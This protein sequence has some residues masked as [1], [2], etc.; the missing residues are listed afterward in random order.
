ML[1]TGAPPESKKLF[2]D[3]ELEHY[4]HSFIAS[5]DRVRYLLLISLVAS[6]LAFMA[7]W[8]SLPISWLDTRTE[9]ARIAYRNKL[10]EDPEKRLEI[11]H[12]KGRAAAGFLDSC[13]T[14][15]ENLQWVSSRKHGEIS[16]KAHLEKLEQLRVDR[17][18]L[19]KVPW[20][21]I[22]FDIN[23]LGAFSGVS[24]S[25]LAMTL[26]FAL[27]RQHENLYLCLWKV[28]K[29]ADREENFSR[30]DSHA[31][32]LYH[33]LAMAQVFT[34]PPSL[35]R[36]RRDPWSRWV[37]QSLLFVPLAVQV[38]ITATN[39]SSFG[40]ARG[41]SA[42]AANINMALQITF[43]ILLACYVF[44][45]YFYVRA[46]DKRWSQAFFTVN[47]HLRDRAHTSWMDWVK[48]G[49]PPGWEFT[50]DGEGCLYLGQSPEDHGTP[51]PH[52]PLAAWRISARE[53]R[54]SRLASALEI[55]EQIRKA[56][57]DHGNEYRFQPSETDRSLY[58]LVRV[59]REGAVQAVAGGKEDTADGTGAEAG[60]S[61]PRLL[62]RDPK[63]P[64][65]YAVDRACIR[66]IHPE[67][68][69]VETLGANPLGGTRS[70]WPRLPGLALA[71]DHML[72]AD[73][74]HRCVW[75]LQ[76]D[77]SNL[78]R[79]WQSRWWWAPAGVVSLDGKI[80]ILE[81]RAL[82]P[83]GVLLSCLWP[84]A[85]VLVVLEPDL[86]RDLK[87]E[88]RPFLSVSLHKARICRGFRE[89]AMDWGH[90]LAAGWASWAHRH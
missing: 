23:D 27:A 35:A 62:C 30:G 41:M 68:G 21:G 73:Y 31:N 46:I 42:Q 14:V 7:Y 25:L 36:W 56:R 16:L 58:V 47:P 13:D 87:A 78:R 3:H 29:V 49:R 20:L 81:H 65:L 51:A 59:T 28:R 6:I 2:D 84:L 64:Y 40:V 67:S 32:F 39:I 17:N 22:D 63:R 75:A 76:W 80:Y 44:P 52:K 1:S 72:V 19:V 88:R 60:F 82:T 24:F 26:C 54:V 8:N 55:P 74:D 10:W 18:L 86:S 85:R 71:G 61:R 4:V 9:K 90:T 53:R 33:A 83:V 5:S 69:K 15:A 48:I 79:V 50:S 70:L 77:G 37:I 11:C 66:R 12:K 45:C 57:D 43:T 38:L 89:R 34:R